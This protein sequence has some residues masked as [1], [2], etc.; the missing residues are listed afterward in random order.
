MKW[1]SVYLLAVCLLIGGCTSMQIEDF[2][3][4]EP[5]FVLED[6]LVGK[7]TAWGLFEDRFGNIQ[8]QFV[9]EIDGKWDGGTLVLKEDFVYND[10]EEETRTWTVVKTGDNTYEGTT[11]NVIGTAYGEIAGNAFH[12]NYDFNLKVGDGYWK[13]NFDDWMFLQPNGVLLNKARVSRW[14]ITIGTVFISFSKP[15]GATA[16]REAA[17][18]LTLAANR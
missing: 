15:A 10:G 11:N 16:R 3:N 17:P 6:Y 7:T 5:A 9:V 1:K 2:Q 8:R 18:V 12:W 4:S 14:G 13:V